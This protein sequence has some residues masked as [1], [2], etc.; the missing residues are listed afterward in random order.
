LPSLLID[1]RPVLMATLLIIVVAYMSIRY[2]DRFLNEANLSSVLLN[3]AQTG[4]L[5]VGMTILMIGGAIDLSVGA[6]LGLAGVVAALLV[7][8]Y[9]VPV[10]IAFLAGFA[11]GAACGAINGVITTRLHINALI[12]TLATL[13]IFRSVTLLVAGTGVTT[14]GR[15]FSWVGEGEF[16]GVQFPFWIM[17]ILVLVFALFTAR[18]RFFRQFF[19][20]GGNPRAA[21]LFGLS[22]D[23]VIFIG[24]VLSGLLAGLAGV[25][26]ASRLDSA[27]VSAGTGVELTVITAAVLGGAA[28][29][30]GAGSIIGS[31]LGVIFITLIQNVLIISKVPVYWQSIVVGVVLIAAVS[32][33]YLQKRRR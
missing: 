14:V 24:F 4:I 5:T 28:L 6:V 32:T 23:R 20:I 7:K 27:I 19:F 26:T 18:S 13:G 12:T 33:E 29:R 17:F 3:A 25:L 16:F 21:S 9:L 2:G 22:P 10:P 1:S 31:F 15:G 8:Q 30:G 11:V